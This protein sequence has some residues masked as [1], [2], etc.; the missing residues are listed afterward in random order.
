MKLVAV[1]KLIVT[2]EQSDA[3]LATTIRVNAARSWLA[4]QAMALPRCDRKSKYALQRLF[5]AEMRERFGIGA[6]IAVRAIA[7]VAACF[8]TDPYAEHTFR[9]KA[10][11][12][13]DARILSFNGEGVPTSV[14]I[15]TLDGRIAL[16]L[17]AGGPHHDRL[18]GERGESDLVLRKGRWYLH[19]SVKV[20]NAPMAEALEFLGEDFGIVR[21][22]TDS[23]GESYCGANVEAVRQRLLKLRTALQECGTRSAKKHLKRL[24]GLE[25]RFR[26][27]TN[28][29]ISKRIVD[30]AKCTGRGIA[31]EDLTGIRD[32]VKVR[33]GQRAQHGSWAF[34]Q[35]RAF[36]TYKAIMAGVPLTIVDPRN[37]SRTCIMC[38]CCDKR[39]R[40][41]Q[42]EFVCKSCGFSANADF[43]AAVNIARRA[44][45]NVP[46]VSNDDTGNAAPLATRVPVEFRRKP[47]ASA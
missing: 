27:D 30:K 7:T 15:A 16:P 25:A 13:Y 11:I 43:V 45:V 42:S 33:K 18:A 46:I 2:R 37:T 47:H 19:T 14:S 17:V 28:H 21:I 6:Q 1:S 20:P 41:S 24:S 4:T 36:V 3:L 38:G 9:E 44:R 10:A 12:S 40:R 32:R 29:V 8:K 39:N 22:A 31:L 23:D 26:T 5:Y 35:L 34:F